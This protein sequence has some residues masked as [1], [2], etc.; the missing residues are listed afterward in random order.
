MISELELG[1]LSLT[2]YRQN[3]EYQQERYSKDAPSKYIEFQQYR[4]EK[5][6]FW[7]GVSEI[8]NPWTLV[9]VASGLAAAGAEY[10]F[11]TYY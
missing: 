10:A 6:S 11:E 2:C 3:E 1:V 8:A 4:A 7:P 5:N 9:C